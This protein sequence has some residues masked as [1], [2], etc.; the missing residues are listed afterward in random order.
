MHKS[1]ILL[2]ILPTNF[3][4]I[5]MLSKTKRTQEKGSLQ[6]YVPSTHIQYPPNIKEARPLNLQDFCTNMIEPSQCYRL[7]QHVRIITTSTGKS[8]KE[9]QSNMALH[10][11][12]KLHAYLDLRNFRTQWPPPHNDADA[13][14]LRFGGIFSICNNKKINQT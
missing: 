7:Q 12:S 6:L 10:V 3:L 1:N 5:G 4:N 14:A 13:Q 8:C 2:K 9:L 11:Q